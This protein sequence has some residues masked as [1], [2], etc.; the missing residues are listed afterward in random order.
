MT[1]LESWYSSGN[2]QYLLQ[3]VRQSLESS[4]DTAFGYHILQLGVSREQSL[5]ECSSINHRMY[6]AQH[7]GGAVGLV[8]H[9]EELPLESDS[10]DI[11][12]AHHTLEFDSNPHQA[13]RE[14]QRVLAPQGH[15]VII[16]FNPYSAFGTAAALKGL[17]RRSAWHQHHPVG[18]HRLTDW[19][20]LLGCEVQA[21]SYL[22]AV[23][24]LGGGKLREYMIRCDRWLNTHNVPI[25]GLYVLHAIKQVTGANR[26]RRRLLSS[27]ERL[28]GLAVPKPTTA[29]SPTPSIHLPANG[30]VA[31]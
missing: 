15:M 4:L 17:S 19:L 2:G 16:G 6:A 23:P 1:E 5:L 12:I 10:I 25:G 30:D 21:C 8:A 20:H 7:V 14:M 18:R 29:P 24:P 26:P 13:L 27:G 11:L 3:H 31:A 9:S 22:Y 28:M